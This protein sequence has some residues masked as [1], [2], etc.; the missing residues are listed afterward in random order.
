ML[1]LPLLLA[2]ETPNLVLREMRAGDG[3]DLACFMT[4][5]RYQRFI[6]HRLKNDDEVNSFVARQVAVQGDARRHIFHLAAEERYS[7]EVVGDGFLIVHGN[8]SV[9]VGWG[10]H[11]A[12]WQVGFGTEIGRA[13]VGLGFERLKAEKVWCKVMRPNLASAKLAGRI[14][15][16]KA[17]THE[18]YPA[19][20]GRFE[21]VDVFALDQDRYFNLPY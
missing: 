15:M 13:L 10:L 4:Q 3:A 19:G 5:P 7:G 14:G 9:E 1:T 18:F 17:E 16:E 20:Q 12:L 2:V 8:K 11:P 21:K 6:V